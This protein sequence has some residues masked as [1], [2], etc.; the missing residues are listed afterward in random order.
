MVS[1]IHRNVLEI[2]DGARDL[3]Q[4]VGGVC[5]LQAQI[6][7]LTTIIGESSTPRISPAYLENPHLCH[8]GLSLDAM[9]SLRRL[10]IFLRTSFRLLSS[11]LEGLARRLS[12]W[13]FSTMIGSNSGLVI[14]A[15]SFDVTNSPLHVLTSSTGYPMLLVQAS[16]IPR[17]SV[18]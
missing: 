9:G 13:L 6:R 14:T 10:S 16:E 7:S 18:N 4:P 3:H 8:R 5:I 11:V 1:E 17:T 2:Q 12:P 15:G